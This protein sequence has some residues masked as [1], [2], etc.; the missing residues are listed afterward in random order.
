MTD[1]ISNEQV[2]TLLQEKMPD[3]DIHIDGDGYHY[4]AIIVSENFSGKSTVDRHKVVYA[5]LSNTIT[6]GAMH[7]LV[8]KTFTPE[9]WAELDKG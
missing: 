9:E 1:V 4:R 6:S 5:A 8:L 3:A 7:A 2:K